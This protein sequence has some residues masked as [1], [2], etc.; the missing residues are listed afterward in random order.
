MYLLLAVQLSV[1]VY[2][3]VC[4]CVC[5]F[6]SSSLAKPG[7]VEK[8]SDLVACGGSRIGKNKRRRIDRNVEIEFLLSHHPRIGEPRREE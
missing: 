2:M 7:R 4:V 5:V 6:P 1:T 8:S 3:H